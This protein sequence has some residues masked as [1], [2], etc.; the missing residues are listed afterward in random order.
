M[1]GVRAFTAQPGLVPSTNSRVVC[2]QLYLLLYTKRGVKVNSTI[3][4]FTLA[5][6]IQNYIT[7]FILN[8]CI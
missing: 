7:D 2:N 3:M 4:E 1:F 5:T 8:Y 6:G